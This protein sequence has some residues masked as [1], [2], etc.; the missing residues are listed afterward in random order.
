[1][2][3]I[4]VII[5][6]FAV[7]LTYCQVQRGNNGL[8][9]DL[10]TP[11]TPTQ[12]NA[13]DT[14]IVLTALGSGK[15]PFPLN[16]R[17]TWGAGTA[18]TGTGTD[19]TW[20][21]GYADGVKHKLVPI[22]EAFMKSINPMSVIIAVTGGIDPNTPL[23]IDFAPQY[24]TGT[25]ALTVEVMTGGLTSVQ[26]IS[27]SM[28]TNNLVET[29]A[30]ASQTYTTV[31]GVAA[32][33]YDSLVAIRAAIAAL[34]Y[35]RAEDTTYYFSNTGNDSN[36]GLSESTPWQTIA[37]F[38]A[39]SFHPANT[40][41]FKR[42]DEWRGRLQINESG[43]SGK[44]ITIDAYG[45]GRKPIF[46]AST[47]QRGW[48]D[49]Y[50]GTNANIW[51]TVNPAATATWQ[52]VIID[53]TLYL[54]VATLAEL[55]TPKKYWVK[56]AS[57][58][59]SIFVWSASDPDARI[60]EVSNNDYAI[61]SYGHA[62][63]TVKNVDVRNAGHSGI[64]WGNNVVGFDGYAV[65]DSIYA[66]RNRLVGVL[67]TGDFD[68]ATITRSEAHYCGN[69]FLS[70]GNQNGTTGP[71]NITFAHNLTSYTQHRAVTP[72]S[73]G[74]GYQ[75]YMGTNCLIEYSESDHDHIGVYF[76]PGGAG[77]IVCDMTGR[78]NYIHDTETGG[79]AA[80]SYWGMSFN[81]FIAGSH[82]RWYY[83]LM[84]NCG[85]TNDNNTPI[86]CGYNT[87]GTIEIYN[88]TIYNSSTHPTKSAIWFIYAGNI[89][90]KI[91]LSAWKPMRRLITIV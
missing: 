7:N 28:D 9:S 45:T 79:D 1:M 74:T 81:N 84:V 76:D 71:N 70:W 87:A 42:G 8:V 53:D 11:I 34:Q 36:D 61:D 32:Q 83:N 52:E 64:R 20:I 5:L 29:R 15:V 78:Y 24:T 60:A 65:G 47:I 41:R 48:A 91:I 23:W 72:V 4:F 46:N 54:Q 59:D 80:W 2:K 12:V 25:R 58:P 14:A 30:H 26:T 49:V 85:N 55:T 51:G 75:F 63:I 68:Y 86:F 57:T 88:N 82:G 77:A 37:K 38:N 17:L 6:L 90:V 43:A 27:A 73:D 69:G 18:Y 66:Y 39:T 22:N 33:L 21:C 3:N 44:P 19:T 13:G 67:I 40:I 10:V 31:A 50:N 89:T 56:T 62:Y 16:L 35:P